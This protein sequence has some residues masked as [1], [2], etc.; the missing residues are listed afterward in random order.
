[1]NNLTDEEI[2]KTTGMTKIE[3]LFTIL[4]PKYDNDNY[5]RLDY[6]KIISRI[7]DYPM[8][9]NILKNKNSDLF[10]KI[11]D[12][13]NK[14]HEISNTFSNTEVHNNFIFTLLPKLFTIMNVTDEEKEA[15]QNKLSDIFENFNI[16]FRT[17]EDKS[18]K[19]ITITI[20]FPQTVDDLIKA[21]T[22]IY[23][24]FGILPLPKDTKKY[25]MKRIKNKSLSKNQHLKLILEAEKSCYSFYN[26]FVVNKFFEEINKDEDYKKLKSLSLLTS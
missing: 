9:V 1:M 7:M 14:K 18:G 24:Y 6:D 15:L 25:L 3:F 13:P 17:I 23:T 8:F 11:S 12:L 19:I 20:N 4:E 5:M 21:L 22:T 16:P 26:R 10:L 2:E